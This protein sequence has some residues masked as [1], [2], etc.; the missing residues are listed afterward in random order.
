MSVQDDVLKVPALSHL[1]GMGASTIYRSLDKIP[2]F[3]VGAAVRFSRTTIE[4]W[5]SS[6]EARALGD[7]H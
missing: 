5:I 7:K 4:T 2:H 3:R 6:Q 1:T